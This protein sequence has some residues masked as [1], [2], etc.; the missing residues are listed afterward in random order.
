[1]TSL[2]RALRD[3]QWHCE[4]PEWNLTDDA[5]TLT[6]G[7]ETDFWQDTFYGFHRDDGHFLGIQTTGD[8][9]AIV[10]FEGAFETLYD[11]AGLML[12]LDRDNWLKAGIEHS[13]GVRNLSV[14]ITRDGRSDWS[15]IA[16]PGSAGT[17][18]L[19]LTRLGGA[20]IVHHLGA[21]DHWHLMRLGNFPK[22]P[23]ARVGPMAC[24][25]Q[26]AGLRVRFLDFGIASPVENPLH[27][28]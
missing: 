9:T 17:Q 19:R 1:M 26:R 8:F 12:R 16:V 4:P 20:A 28:G 25:P 6:T 3:A 5:L 2:K 27:G 13:D 15:V 21:D 24:S 18:T 11:Q 7:N 23:T 14:V 10:T 22:T